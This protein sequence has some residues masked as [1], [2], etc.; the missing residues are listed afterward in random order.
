MSRGRC[1]IRTR[2]SPVK[3][4]ARSVGQPLAQFVDACCGKG[5]TLPFRLCR[6]FY[7]IG[8][9]GDRRD[10]VSANELDWNS[11]KLKFAQAEANPFVRRDYRAGVGCEGV[12]EGLKGVLW[13]P[14]VPVNGSGVCHGT[15][16]ICTLSWGLGDGI[17]VGCD[18]GVADR[19]VDLA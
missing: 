18:R 7:R 17:Q 3:Y 16:T 6:T 14:W 13:C 5:Q 1:C 2:S 19:H 10:A 11:A 4:L 12:V 15:V 9:V 8:F